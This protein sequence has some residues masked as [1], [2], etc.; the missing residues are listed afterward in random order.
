MHLLIASLLTVLASVFATSPG[1]RFVGTVPYALPAPATYSS[2]HVDG[3]YM[4]V[5]QL[6]SRAEGRGR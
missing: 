1:R 2:C 3:P 5:L 6:C 4:D